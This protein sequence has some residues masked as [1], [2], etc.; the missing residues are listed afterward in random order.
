MSK[1]LLALLLAL[2]MIV[3]SFTSVLADPAKE[4]VKEDKK[5]EEKAEEKKDEKSEEKKD[6][7]SEEKKEEKTEEKTEEKKEE[8]KDEYLAKAIEVLKKAG[9]ISGYSKD[10]DDF[11]VEK[12]VTR[13]EFA[14]MIVRA[15]GLEASAKA[16]AN[17]P[18]G[19]KDVPANL[20]ANG[21]IAVAKQQGF[22]NGYPNGTF[23]PNKQVSYQDM[24]TML[25]IA[26]GKAEAGTVY[27]A[28]YIVKAQQLGLFKN[29]DVPAY[30]DMATRG[31][32]FKM[33]Y[34][35]ITSKEFGERKIVKAI[36]LENKR[37]ENL[38]DDEITVE[39]L[40]VVQAAN[41][42][43]D[44]REKKGDQHTYKLDK[45]L[46]LDAE[47]LLGKVIDITTNKDDQIVNVTVD[48]TFDYV[49]GHIDD[50]TPKTITVND[51]KYTVDFDERYDSRDERIF[52]TYLNNKNYAYRDFAEDY[53][54]QYD[55]VRFTVKNGK[56]IF[57]D[58]YQFY[59][60]APVAE[61][62]D[63]NV[64]YYDD[65][66][67]KDAVN[68][69]ITQ[70][71]K[72]TGDI[73][74]KSGNVYSVGER[75][76]IVKDDVLHFYE[77]YRINT[78]IKCAIVRKDA[79]VQ[80]KLV[81]THLDKWSTQWA[82]GEK[83]EYW[84]NEDAPYRLIASY[85]GKYFD[86]ITSRH[87]L[88]KLIGENVK[89]LVALDGSAQLIQSDKAWKDG[90]HAVKRITSAG[91]VN[92]LPPR[93]DAFWAKE[94][95]KT[96]YIALRKIVNNYRLLDFKY[97]DIVYYEGSEENEIGAM[98]LVLPKNNMLGD[99]DKLIEGYA[100][101]FQKAAITSRYIT[102][103]L[104]DYRYFENVNAYYV[105]KRGNLQNIPDF[106]AFAKDQKDNAKLEAYVMSEGKLKKTLEGLELELYNFL[107][108][109]EEIANIVVFKNAVEKIGV[110]TVYAVVAD[111][112][113]KYT[114]AP[115]TDVRF[116][117]ADG[118]VYDV[119]LDFRFGIRNFVKGDIVK[120]NLDKTT[121]EKDQLKGYVE[122]VVI[123]ADSE[124]SPWYSIKTL[125]P[126]D[127][128]M[129]GEKERYFTKDTQI[130]NKEYGNEVQVAYEDDTNFVL[131]IRYREAEQKADTYRDILDPASDANHLVLVGKDNKQ[132]AYGVT[133]NTEF[134]DKA[135][136]ILGFGSSY[137]MQA[138][139][140][141][142]ALYL[143]G[144][145]E[146]TLDP[147][148]RFAL[149]VKGLRDQATIISDDLDAAQKAVEK[150]GARKYDFGSA[151]ATNKAAFK[152]EA[153]DAIKKAG[154]ADKVEVDTVTV[155]SNKLDTV[156]KS[157]VDSTKTIT[158]HN[159]YSVQAE[160]DANQAKADLVKK[161]AN[162]G[163]VSFKKPYV[164]ATAKSEIVKEI[165]AKLTIAKAGFT[166]EAANIGTLTP[167]DANAYKFEVTIGTAPNEGKV[168]LTFDVILTDD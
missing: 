69:K 55:F 5:T 160:K 84:L 161:L 86:V 60:I 101:N 24:A 58:A 137:L 110:K 159:D 23:Q 118:K 158:A 74:F 102:C 18:T 98:G 26:L 164:E 47:D 130:F 11:K 30:T 34:N 31:N 68:A 150:L 163:R 146:V 79:K 50:V 88:K 91:E 13:A 45:D 134:R 48:K 12:N 97:D 67:N 29:V 117:D 142:K 57:I 96:N 62:K 100:D 81:K 76:E 165:K 124:K 59:D 51:T 129:I 36:V 125:R 109:S 8:V 39:V 103:G 10:S 33:L 145:V 82:V 121:L 93:T 166:V 53:K 139:T 41:W 108:T 3:G 15:K 78:N 99:N 66:R 112:W 65:T 156:I 152:V 107:S 2:V 105:D 44:N 40:K 168:E 155:N 131:A 43:Q 77:N 85:E 116:V 20:W 32:V 123:Y 127:T 132:R 140:G 106:A 144:E 114:D 136:K 72:L 19:F 148:G 9:F 126:R 70:A 143:N 133:A 28:G 80:T 167:V 56:V 42:V 14:S 115:T 122:K 54:K 61:V 151:E 128:Y 71:P 135:N 157:K 113:T 63:G 89:L 75:K 147:T 154:L 35:M 120:L 25:T 49:E 87:Q 73:I 95:R 46:K 27:P 138:T 4:P 153:E 83:D 94:T 37:V 149:L 111:K 104:K 1:K 17:L 141:F 90:I 162:N 52:R 64:F 21:Y 119:E 22:V 38:A 6:E 92:L 7:K 16:L